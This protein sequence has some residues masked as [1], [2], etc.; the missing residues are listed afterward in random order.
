MTHSYHTDQCNNI[1]GVFDDFMIEY[2]RMK[3]NNFSQYPNKA[4]IR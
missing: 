1:A 3:P 4:L 2:E